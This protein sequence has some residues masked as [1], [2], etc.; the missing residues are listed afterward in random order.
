M[1]GAVGARARRH[2]SRGVDDDHS[3]GVVVATQAKLW[4]WRFRGPS[5]RS[6]RTTSGRGVGRYILGLGRCK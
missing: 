3:N 4:L 6:V 5:E 1:I 2:L